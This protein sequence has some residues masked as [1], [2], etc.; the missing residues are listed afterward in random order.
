MTDGAYITAHDLQFDASAEKYT[1]L[2]LK[3]VRDDADR[4]A[5]LRAMSHCSGNVSDAA[6]LLGV[7]RPTLYNL[8]EKL[9][10]KN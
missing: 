5:V 7:T 4:R 9:G 3:E 1:P 10:L 8:L 2:N 6:N